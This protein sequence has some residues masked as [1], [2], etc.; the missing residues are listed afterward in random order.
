LLSCTEILERHSDYIDGLMPSDEAALW[1][2][3]IAACADCSRYDAVLRRG[4]S[5]LSAHMIEPDGDFMK[6]LHSRIADEEQ[7]AARPIS[8]TTATSVSVAAVL[9]L[10]AWLPIM[11]LSRDTEGTSAPAYASDIPSDVASWEIAWHGGPA[12][13]Q[14][15]S[16]ARLAN[17]SVRLASAHASVSL[18]DR[19]Y[20]PLILES[21]VA[22][23][24]YTRVAYT[25]QSR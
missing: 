16:H 6:Q 21:P 15:R 10:A 25:A 18:I 11:L 5:M 9:A 19:G 1:A 8:A 12:V 14:S 20:T 24:S 4:I 17:R 7:R 3:H 2:Q 22:P 23:P 13:H